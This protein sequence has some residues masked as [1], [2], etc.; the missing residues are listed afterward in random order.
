MKNLEKKINANIV[1]ATSSRPHFGGKTKGK[2]GITLI[3]LIITI[4]VMLILAGVTVNV[5]IQGGMFDT[6]RQAVAQTEEHSIYDQIVGSMKIAT[7]GNIDV[8]GTYNAAKGILESQGKTTRL[9]APAT[10]DEIRTSATFS[11][12][13]KN[14]T[15]TYTITAE[16]IILGVIEQEQSNFEIDVVETALVTPKYKATIQ[17]TPQITNTTF[18]FT[19]E[20]EAVK[21]VAK[22]EYSDK[23]DSIAASE[24]PLKD[25]LVLMV[26]DAV[27]MT[28]TDYD[29]MLAALEGQY[30]EGDFSTPQSSFEFYMVATNKSYTTV[31]EY[32]A[33]IYVPTDKKLIIDEVEIETGVTWNG[34]IATY[35]IG[36]NGTY[37]V[38]LELDGKIGTETIE[39]SG[40]ENKGKYVKYDSDS[41]GD[42]TDEI[43]FRVLYD[44]GELG[45]GYGA[46][47]VVEDILKMEKFNLGYNNPSI[48]E[49]KVEQ[50]D[51][52]SEVSDIEKAFYV[53]NNSVNILNDKCK[54]LITEKEGIT[55]GVRSLGS[56]PRDPYEQDEE[57]TTDMFMK[58]EI[59]G[60]DATKNDW[61]A[62]YDGKA[63]KGNT[64]E[65]E[66]LT[67]LRKNKIV[68]I[69]KGSGGVYFAS[70]F[71]IQ[72]RTDDPERLWFYQ[73]K[74][75]IIDYYG[76]LS[77]LQYHQALY[78]SQ[79]SYLCQDNSDISN[80]MRLC[81]VVTL[82]EGALQ[83]S[84]GKG[85]E[86]E[87]LILQ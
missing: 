45:Q 11:V 67:E 43:L 64:D 83:N 32:A 18:A 71:G 74:Y 82:V 27:G 4:I 78:M 63:K 25:L 48:D 20:T 23:Y 12:V 50:I 13:G 15:Y 41:D 76:D 59:P 68:K 7:D 35:E 47:I 69:S 65:P 33:S 85:T 24:E 16:E 56:N 66:D 80:M 37:K 52:N 6:A 17:V 79:T 5:A 38:Q 87:P 26:S 9:V 84:T 44:E 86:S 34:N 51:D 30:P 19:D 53:Y 62:L 10:E 39:I 77:T 58:T 60:Y 40:I 1:G 42:L 28:F 54:S 72:T 75:V 49:T 8:K 29:T 57:N 14:G 81:P 31:Q 46:Q 3:A 61:F 2:K 36:K 21:Y 73:A 55:D 22:K 70:R